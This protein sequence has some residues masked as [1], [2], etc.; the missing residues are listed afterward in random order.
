MT[1]WPTIKPITLASLALLLT[2][3]L[4]VEAEPLPLKILNWNVLYGFNHHKALEEGSQ[5]LREQKPDIIAFQEL[6]GISENE[7]AIHARAW[8][9]ENAVTH[10]D[11]GFPLGLTSKAPITVLERKVEGFHHGY[12]HCKTYGI[13]FFVVHFWPGKFDEADKI[14]SKTESLLAQGENVIVLGDFNGCSRRDDTFLRNHAT[15]RDIDYTFV[16]K[17]EAADFVDII[18]KHDPQAKVSCPSPITIPR[19]T[20]N[21]EELK[22]KQYRIDFIF[23]DRQLAARSITGTILLNKKLD[24]ISDHYPVIIELE[25]PQLEPLSNHNNKE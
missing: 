23:A 21:L 5:W 6:N 20:K 13:H 16:D 15:L 1:P 17:V 4:R 24:H 19:W 9:H 12:L 7:L 2:G 3:C 11:K 10:K 18:A 14:L 22:Q 8:R 25:R